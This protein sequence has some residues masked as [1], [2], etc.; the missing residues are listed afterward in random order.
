M[1]ANFKVSYNL[2]V[3]F[4]SVI[5]VYISTTSTSVSSAYMSRTS[6]HKRLLLVQP[7]AS[8]TSKVSLLREQFSLLFF[9]LFFKNM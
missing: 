4:K 3:I 2:S 1:F 6:F 5:Q 7:C 9:I 8:K